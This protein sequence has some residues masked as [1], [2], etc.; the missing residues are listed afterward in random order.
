MYDAK[1][2]EHMKEEKVNHYNK[3]KREYIDSKI[4]HISTN[5][6]SFGQRV[7]TINAYRDLIGV[8]YGKKSKLAQAAGKT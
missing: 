2:L 8:F 5:W 3:I 6:L 7:D 4:K 1:K